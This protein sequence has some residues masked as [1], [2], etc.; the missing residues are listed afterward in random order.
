M[1]HLTEEQLI[2]YPDVE[3][4]AE[5]EAH[6]ESCAACRAACQEQQRMLTAVRELPEPARGE[7]YGHEVWQRLRPR[8]EPRPRLTWAGLLEALLPSAQPRWAFAL[9][10]ALLVAAA[11]VAGR[12]W[13]RPAPVS[14]EQLRASLEP[15]IRSSLR[16][17]FDAKLQAAVTQLRWQLA[18]LAKPA[19][20]PQAV[21]AAASLAA[22]DEV[23]RLWADFLQGYRQAQANDRRDILAL[24]RDL[25][26]FAVLA[27]QDLDMTQ[28]QIGFLAANLGPTVPKPGVEAR[29]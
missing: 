3:P 20:D 25:E 4:R 29:P 7:D 9:I 19:P 27:E 22:R 23:D 12:L 6:L 2:L 11:F 18:G 13:P 17:E 15:S 26:A 1:K 21:A 14:V 8:L 16:A 10:M 28:R 5:V 24:R